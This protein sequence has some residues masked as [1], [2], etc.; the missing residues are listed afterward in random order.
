MQ[1]MSVS[2]KSLFEALDD[3]GGPWMDF[4]VLIMIWIWAMVFDTPIFNFLLSMLILN[5]QRT[6][7]PFISYFGFWRMLEVPDLGSW[8]LY[9]YGQWSFIQMY[10]DFLLSILI[11]EVQGTS[12]SFK[13]WFG[14]VDNFGG[15]W[16]G[17]GSWSWFG[18]IHLPLKHQ[19]SKFWLSSLIWKMLRTSVSFNSWCWALKEA[20][21]SWLEILIL[22]LILIWLVCYT[23]NPYFGSLSFIWRCKE[24]LCSLSTCVGL[25]R[26]LKVSHWVFVFWFQ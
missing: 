23:H 24:H 22:I 18:Y 9:E 16:L 7:C 4:G 12:T 10:S 6:S 17:F 13:S 21:V 1:R 11:L 25:W 26:M 20:W 8:F 3:P 5:V 15:L 19:W 2:F 14:G